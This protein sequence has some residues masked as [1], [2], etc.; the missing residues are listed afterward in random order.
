M[1]VFTRV[2][3]M[4]S[5]SIHEIDAQPRAP[6]ALAGA[7]FQQRYS[8]FQHASPPLLSMAQV[9]GSDS[10]LPSAFQRRL[11]GSAHE[12]VLQSQLEQPSSAMETPGE[13]L[14]A[15]RLSVTTVRAGEEVVVEQTVGYLFTVNM[16]R[17][18]LP[19][20]CK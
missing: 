7:N 17:C 13:T 6:R 18:L 12:P 15:A 8:S 9:Q 1:L 19:W 16:H 4:Q 3:C 20:S 2:A 14:L 10:T 11:S 5:S